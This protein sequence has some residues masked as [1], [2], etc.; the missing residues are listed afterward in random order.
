MCGRFTL[1]KAPE[2]IA[3]HFGVEDE[4]DIIM[5]TFS[6]A[7]GGFGA[8]IACDETVKNYLINLGGIL[9]KDMIKKDRLA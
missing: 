4:T 2:E 3:E 5:G 9:H 6:K 1:R 7:L 8:Y